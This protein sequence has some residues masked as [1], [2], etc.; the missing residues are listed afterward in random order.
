MNDNWEKLHKQIEEI[1]DILK[2]YAFVD[3][4]EKLVEINYRISKRRKEGPSLFLETVGGMGS[5]NDLTIYP[6]NNDKIEKGDVDIVNQV[7]QTTISKA[8]SL[9]KQIEKDN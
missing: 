1:I 9:A 8:Y 7:L 3:W 5:L 2:K 4:A 6:E